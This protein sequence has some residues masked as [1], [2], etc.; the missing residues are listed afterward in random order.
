VTG[1]PEF[2]LPFGQDRLVPIFLATLAVRQKSQTVR[3]RSA[4]EILDLFGMAKGGKEYRRFIAAFERIFGATIFFGTESGANANRIVHRA[5]FNFMR[6]ATIW[7][8]AREGGENS[9]TLTDEFY[10]EVTAHPI[11]NNL[12]IVRLL[13]PSPGAMD[14]YVWL[15]YR[16]FT[17]KG[18]QSIPVFGP[19]GLAGQL[20]SA[21][22]S[23]ARRFLV[24]LKHWLGEVQ[25]VWPQC[26]ANIKGCRLEIRG[27]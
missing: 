17:A 16:C 10:A 4:A 6:E 27:S 13:A 24:T 20:G 11:P 8:S 12:D 25:V 15:A 23:R 1:H 21:E 2:G 7:Y 19:D 26:P 22:Y 9:V 5:R 3:F 18:P 14:L